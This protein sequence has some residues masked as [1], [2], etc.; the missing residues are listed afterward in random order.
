M[1]NLRIFFTFRAFGCPNKNVYNAKIH[2]HDLQLWSI[3]LV[4]A[5]YDFMIFC[6]YMNPSENFSLELLEEF[7]VEAE[8]VVL[9]RNLVCDKSK[10]ANELMLKMKNLKNLRNCSKVAYH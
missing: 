1:N 8:S 7:G 10:V 5:K 4:M 9:Q 6:C 3:L 2:S